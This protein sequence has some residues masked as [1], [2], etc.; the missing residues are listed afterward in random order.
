MNVCKSFSIQEYVN[1]SLFIYAYV[2]CSV[3][4][5][6]L[7]TSKYILMNMNAV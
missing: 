6:M 2:I 5:N 4:K 1:L 7:F 3:F